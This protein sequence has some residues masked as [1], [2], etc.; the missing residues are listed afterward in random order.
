MQSPVKEIYQSRSDDSW[1]SFMTCDIFVG[2]LDHVTV[3]IGIAVNGEAVAGVI[4]Q[5]YFNYKEGPEAQLGRTIWG[6]V[7]LGEINSQ[8]EDYIYYEL[9]L[10]RIVIK[11]SRNVLLP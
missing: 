8:R 6:V 2:L 4:H 7:G 11:E 5:P 1:C 10:L 3:L 9:G